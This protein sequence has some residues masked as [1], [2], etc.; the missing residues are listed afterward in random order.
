MYRLTVI[1]TTYNRRQLLPKAIESVRDCGDDVEVI[2]VDDA[3]TDDTRNYCEGLSGI[4]YIRQEKNKGTAAARNRG[5]AESR[6]PYV[7]FLDD[8]DW[9]LP[10]TFQPQVEVLEKNKN[11]AVVYGKV[12]YANQDQTLS[13]H[14]NL[15]VPTPAGDVLLELLQRN[16]ITLSSVVARKQSMIDAGL[17]DDS[18][19]MLGLEDWDLW[20]RL[21]AR[22]SIQGINEPVAVYR[23]PEINS[24]Q[25]YSDL[26]RQFS[27][28]AVAYRKKWFLLPGLK[29]K[30]GPAYS[31]TKRE[32]LARTSD[33]ILYSAIHHSKDRREKMRRLLAAVRCNP[34]HLVNLHFYKN[35]VTVLL[36][37]QKN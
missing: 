27:L 24:G 2:V 26:G 10:G 29:E 20:L 11:C 16:F 12:Y 33:I 30:L 35:V 8:D 9:R 36:N 34:R 13:G 18:R 25:W 22:H 6:A 1:I 21:S 14:S 4:R 37:G 28:A 7:A 32:I 31:R 23:K 19:N 3:S 5:I 17:F 15:Q